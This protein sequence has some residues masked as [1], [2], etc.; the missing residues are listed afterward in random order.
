MLEVIG[1][2][3]QGGHVGGTSRRSFLKVGALTALGL[4]LPQLLRLREASAASAVRGSRKSVILIWMH[5]GP[6]QLETY[7]PKPEAPAEYRGPYGAIETNV[8][9]IR[10]SEKLPLQARIMDKLTI[11]RAFSHGNGDHFAAA[12]WVLTGYLGSTAASKAPL[13]PSMGSIAAKLRGPNAPDMLPYVNMNDGGFGYHGSAFLGVAYNPFRAGS[14]S[15]GNEGLAL[16]EPNS[17]SFSLAGGITEARFA[18]RRTLLA[19]LDK[20]RRDIDSSGTLE[21]MDRFQRTAFEI[22]LSGSARRA[23]DLGEEDPRTRELYGPGWGEQALLARRLVEAGV[24][25]VTLNTGYW[26]DHANL[27]GAMESK[28]PRHDRM[29]SALVQ[30]LDA[31]GLLDDTLVIAAGEF[32]RTPRMNAQGGRDHWPQAQSIL[33]AGGGF[34]HGQVIGATDERA[35]YPRDNPMGPADLG[36]IVYHALGIDTHLTNR[37]PSG[38]PIHVLQGGRVPPELLG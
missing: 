28:L 3:V 25:F 30:D 8:P 38:R 35:E 15:Y 14:D 29:V 27:K 2:A 17:S 22:I 13:Y 20:L 4:T 9:G 1:N 7:D 6:T 34:R 19:N 5:G 32:G 37:N 10:I 23:F 36:A 26:D 33:L 11:H 31:R 21:G 24:T 12:H 18:Q 16:A